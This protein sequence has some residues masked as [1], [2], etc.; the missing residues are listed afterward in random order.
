MYVIVELCVTI[1]R[2]NFFLHINTQLSEEGEP[3]PG[4]NP[5]MLIGPYYK[6]C[7]YYSNSVIILTKLSA[8]S[9]GG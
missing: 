2:T 3:N 6:I 1:I 9:G 5:S 4:G 8:S 7:G